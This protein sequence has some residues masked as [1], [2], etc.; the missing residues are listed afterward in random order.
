[1]HPEVQLAV[2]FLRAIGD[3]SDSMAL[4]QLA[5]S[6]VY[7]LNP[8]DLQ[9]INTF[10]KRR[11]YTLHHVF[12]H[13][14]DKTGEFEVLSDIKRESRATVRKIMEDI[15]Y[16]LDFAKQKTTGE[17]LYLFLKRS[18]YLARLTREGSPANDSRLR[19]LASFFEKVR[20]FKEVAE[21]DRVSEFVK[22]LNI[23]K[24]SGDNPESA[25]VDQ[26]VDAVNVLTVHKA[27][28]LEFRTVFLV[29]LVAEKFPVRR[30]GEP[31]EIPS[32]LVKEGIPAGDFHL[33]EERRLF[34][35]GMTRAK[36]ELYLTSAAD[37]GGK[38][39]RK[40]SRFVLEALDMPKADISLIKR[41]AR[42]Q[43][44][45]FASAEIALP[46]IKKI[47]KD[48]ILPLSYYQMDDY[49]T[50]PLKYKYVHVLRVPL[51]PNHQIIYGKALHDAVGAMNIAKL[52]RQKFSEKDLMEVLL[53][54]WSSE[55]FISRDHEEQRLKNAKKALKLFY[56]N[57][58]K[59]KR[60]IKYVEEKFSVPKGNV[61]IR[62]RW[63]RVDEEGGRIIIL[64]Y[65]S[66]EVKKQEEA[67]RRARDNL[68][69]SIYALVWK[70]RFGELPY[71][72]ELNFLENGLVGSAKKDEKDIAK[73]WEK[74]KKVADGIRQS[75]FVSKPGY[76]ACS[77]CPYHE[78]CPA[79]A[80]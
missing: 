49:L 41:S 46:A 71:R 33:Q 78:I 26:D 45:L 58:K 13:F 1:M 7:E 57:Q 60:K 68:Q 55:G 43:I 69:L 21:V 19:N 32:E 70:E 31:I 64:D 37:Y 80:D 35:V 72:V 59:S 16:Y 66:S 11:N 53:K 20:E 36:K 74:I 4:F 42:E 54:S 51:L 47:K 50:C 24:E 30:R 12:T 77:Y 56:R 62:G 61:V 10:A 48:E 40:V 23:L 14:E 15:S 8:L 18:G 34:Y 25:V 5:V 22:Y 2:S 29:S 3:L 63:D 52:N 65:K 76:K 67:D 38:R 44:E 73:T 75:N 27:K 39:Q 79:S 6:P 17:V 28:G 9:K